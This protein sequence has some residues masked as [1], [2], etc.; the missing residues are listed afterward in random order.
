M[1]V[2][3]CFIVLYLVNSTKPVKTTGF[4]FNSPPRIVKFEKNAL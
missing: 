3:I 4:L 2:I 1:V